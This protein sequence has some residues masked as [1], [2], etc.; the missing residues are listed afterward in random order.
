MPAREVAFVGWVGLR[1]AVPIILATFP[2]LAR[3]PGAERIFDVV[4]F[5]V[6]VNAFLPGWTVRWAAAKLGL[7]MP[8]APAPQA[9]LEISSSL[10]MGDAIT[11][12]YVDRASA[13]AGAAIADLPL[14]GRTSVLLVVRG[15]EVFAARGNTVLQPGDHVHVFCEPDDKPLVQLLFGGEERS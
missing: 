4:F 1:G 5:V 12:F 9:V 13:V 8:R 2:V 7:E 14:P 3:A 10:A 11:S 15:D 6:V